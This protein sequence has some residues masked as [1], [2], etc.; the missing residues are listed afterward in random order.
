MTKQEIVNA[1]NAT[2]V[3]NGQK[4]ISAESL[5]NILNEMV[6]AIPEGGSGGGEN[7]GGASVYI[8]KM[9]DINI[10][11]STN[12]TATIAATEEEKVHNATVYSECIAMMRAG[13]AVDIKLDLTA[14]YTAISPMPISFIQSTP[15]EIMYMEANEEYGIPTTIMMSIMDSAFVLFEDGSVECNLYFSME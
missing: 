5:N 9:S 2:I 13:K 1:I 10:E 8:V 12:I 7:T 3:A 4:G 14:L 6:N 15:P 11:G